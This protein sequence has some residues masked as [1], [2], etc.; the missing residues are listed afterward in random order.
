MTD[1]IQLI[2]VIRVKQM[3]KGE[4]KKNSSKREI[5]Y[6]WLR[7]AYW[8]LLPVLNAVS[9]QRLEDRRKGQACEYLDTNRV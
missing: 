3:N 6:V 1:L 2:K 5:K 9:R 8:F 7:I 4:A